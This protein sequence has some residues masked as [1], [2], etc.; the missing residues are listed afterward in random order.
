MTIIGFLLQFVV[1]RIPQQSSQLK[2]G[3][4]WVDSVFVTP[5]IAEMQVGAND[6]AFPNDC[7]FQTLGWLMHFLNSGFQSE[8]IEEG[9]SW[10]LS[11][12]QAEVFRRMFEHQLH[13]T[14]LA[15]QI[16]QPHSMHFGGVAGGSPEEQLRSLLEEHGVP[17]EKLHTRVG[18]IME[19]IGRQGIIQCCRSPRP[20]HE[21][22]ALA[23]SQSPKLQLILPSELAEKI[24]EKS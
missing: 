18:L 10:A 23:N 24:R 5:S 8:S 16:V 17:K 7:G 15:Q 12:T 9:N 2:K 3:L 1:N 20:W 11:S 22:K 19:R 21:L 6:H 14:G 4:E 13:V